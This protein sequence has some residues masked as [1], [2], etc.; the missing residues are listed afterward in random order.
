MSELLDA[1]DFDQAVTAVSDVASSLFWI[2]L[3]IIAMEAILY[4]LLMARREDARLTGVAIALPLVI[5]A[6]VLLS[7]NEWT[8][9]LLIALAATLLVLGAIEAAIY[10]FG[11]RKRTTSKRLA[12]TIMLLAPA[13]VGIAILYVYPLYYEFSLSFTK[14][15]I[16]NFVDPGLFFGLTMEGTPLE[17]WGA[18]RDIFIGLQNYID[19]F[20]KPVL[21]QTG[22]WQL[23]AQTLIWTVVGIFFH[24]TLG[25]GL[26]LML[27]RK[28]RGRTI[29][30]ALLILPWAIPVFIS[31]Q[32]WRTEYNFQFGAVNQVL[33]LFGVP[34]QQWLSD[35]TMNFLAMIITNVWLGVPFMMVITLGG[36]Q[37]ISQEYYEAAEIDGANGRQQFRGITLP[38][39]RPVLIPAILLGVFLTFN[40]INVPFFIN[41]NELETSDI[42]VTALYRAGFQFSRFGF[43]AAF[44]FVVFGILLAFT[45]WYVRQTKILKGSYES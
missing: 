9:D 11:V 36:L 40:N 22:F 5:A 29:Y 38:L 1:F 8:A 28:L 7:S 2:I 26:A 6:G 4:L 37:S 10:W 3:A 42:L 34:P 13:V 35:P 12:L 45:I 30:R 21:K 33:A 41:Q 43:A 25:V 27:N 17:P 39:L 16:R 18:E 20:T 15:N 31:L 24:V 23:L 32:I 44:A 14:M 19:V